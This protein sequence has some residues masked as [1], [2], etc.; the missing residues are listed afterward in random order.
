MAQ[1]G[2]RVLGLD[3]GTN[4]VGWALLEI[5]ANGDGRIVRCGVRAFEAGMEG[6]I[7][8]G[9]EE[10][11]GKRRREMRM[12]RRQTERRARR[13]RN[14]ARLL[15]RHGLLPEGEV[16]AP[17]ARHELL[18][19]L[20]KAL[21]KQFSA[22]LGESSAANGTTAQLPYFLRAH[23]LDH[24]LDLHAFGRALYHLAQRRGFESNRIKPES[25]EETGKVKAGIAELDKLMH[26]TGA[27]T[28]GEYFA[29]IDPHHRR[30]RTR[31]TA[32]RMYKDEFEL[33][34]CA[35]AQHHPDLLTPDLKRHI[36]R[37][38]FH[39]RPLKNQRGLIGNCEFEDGRKRAPWAL[40]IA[41][42][43]RLLQRVNDLRIVSPDAQ[44][45]PLAPEE[46][47]QL[48]EALETN[49]ELSFAEIRR[50]LGVP[51]GF[52]I[53]L[54]KGGEK[55]LKGNTTAAKLRAVF[56]ERWDAFEAAEREQAVEDLRSIQK[57]DA[58]FRRAQ[59]AWGLDDAAAK[60][61]SQ[62]T[63]EPDYCSLSRQALSKLVPLMEQGMNYMDAVCA[64]YGKPWERGRFKCEL[65]PRVDEAGMELRNPAVHRALTEVRKVVNAVVRAYGRPDLMRIELAR[66]LRRS[67]KERENVS[68]RMRQNEKRRADAKAKVLKE[69]PG[70][71][72]PSRDDIL[73]VMLAEECEW[74]CPYTGKSI[75]MRSLLGDTPQFD[76][77]H[78]VPFS[79]S[80]DD[81]FLNKTL[82]YHEENRSRKGNRAPSEAYSEAELETILDRVRKFKGD[83]RDE[84]LRRFMLTEFE[85]F[86]DFCQRQL[87][88]T[89][90]TARLAQQYLGLLY[91]GVVDPDG[92]RRIQATRG[93]VTAEL[94]RAWK[95]NNILGDGTKSRDD[96]R[97]HA[98]DA[99][100][101][102]LATLAMVKSISVAASRGPE[103]GK[104][105]WWKNVPEPWDGFLKQATCAVAEV[106]VSHR[107]SRKVNGALHEE[108]I[109]S[110]H[111]DEK[112][113]PC[114]HVRK[115]V[116]AL[117]GPEI[118]AI[119]DPAVRR[120]VKARLAELGGE[121]KKA[122]AKPEDCP[123]LETKDG[124]RVPIRRVR[125]RKKVPVFK[126][127]DEHRVR[128]VTT[129]RNHHVEI[130][131]VSKNGK[132]S[133][134]GVVVSTFDAVQRRR[135]GLPIV[136]TEH[137][138]GRRF[139]FSLALND[140]VQ[141]KDGEGNLRLFKIIGVSQFSAGA[142]V[143]DFQE[144]RDARQV[145]KIPRAGRT[146]TPDTMRK[147]EVQKV[148]ITPL[149]DIRWAND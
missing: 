126:I 141:M 102:A 109:Y 116:N 57:V 123:W 28:L 14:L 144:N 63:L 67:R 39:Q 22:Q 5:E 136:K 114:V 124:K 20:D 127:G 55:K 131:E 74:K 92:R 26:E 42:R 122:F 51:R 142:I 46:R 82:C 11:R 58:L 91:G 40:P 135:A 86:E 137:G 6:D 81:S 15:Q 4:S 87:N 143:I 113:Q 16:E 33:L 95:L 117:S 19:D 75:C 77:E 17:Q 65:L 79:R 78:I 115:P 38:I 146:R 53:N 12:Q 29:G 49:A 44:E 129:D 13:G 35:Q 24:S 70:R 104:R 41:Q 100:A 134:D 149:G 97:H 140:S 34:W 27:R 120:V 96:H 90:Y 69:M 107:P 3:I 10:S 54:E 119:V 98:V 147:S 80:L 60:A 52:R 1:Q 112:G 110:P 88:D 45:R 50:R 132:T 145:S 23:A 37:C 125:L 18:V 99:I 48:L 103:N 30:I 59:S 84:K 83:A 2:E 106:V 93:G 32:R 25:D 56:G 111:L 148:H 9:R 105:R 130:V 47:V 66:D 72:E 8:S 21:S 71:G 62:C 31:W 139:L 108:T 138:E 118:E 43:F 7:S 68:S 76:I 73:K 121:P 85:D 94:R 89:R 128:H 64:V 36:Y 101:T 61:F 133:W